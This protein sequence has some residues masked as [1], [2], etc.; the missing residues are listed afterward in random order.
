MGSATMPEVPH[1]A[2]ALRPPELQV[3][4]ERVLCP[5]AR[6]A[7]RSVVRGERYSCTRWCEV[8]AV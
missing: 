3:E 1:C 8:S 6:S 5:K 2:V 7:T 4:P